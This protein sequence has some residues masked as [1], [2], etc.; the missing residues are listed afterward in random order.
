[1]CSVV[2][3]VPRISETIRVRSV[4]G[5][6]LEHSRIL[7][8][9][10]GDREQFLIGSADMMERNLDR[11]VEALVPVTEPALQDRLRY[12]L[13][14][15]LQDDRRAWQLDHE[16][17]WRRVETLLTEPAGIDTFETLM[18]LASIVPDPLAQVA[19]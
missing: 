19:T 18:Q 15:M 14:V 2:P 12:I 17:D 5:R 11:R 3:G 6:Y 8:F 7:C 1:M 16:G 9:G 4:I 10:Q 13:E